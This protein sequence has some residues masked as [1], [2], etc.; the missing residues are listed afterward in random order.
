[1]RLACLALVAGL[2]ACVCGYDHSAQPQDDPSCAS[3]DEF[4]APTRESGRAYLKDVSA[5]SVMAIS[6]GPQGG[7]MVTPTVCV[8][9]PW[10]D[11]DAYETTEDYSEACLV[12]SV[13]NEIVNGDPGAPVSEGSETMTRFVRAS[14]GRWCT[15]SFWNYLDDC[16]ANLGGTSLRMQLEVRGAGGDVALGETEVVLEAPPES[17]EETGSGSWPWT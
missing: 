11:D 2:A 1:M 12:L 4:D 8:D 7:C 10:L 15:A 16:T 14:D 13:T 9:A 3:P 17:P 5:G 6:Q